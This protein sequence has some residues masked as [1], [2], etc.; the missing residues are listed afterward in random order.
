MNGCKEPRIDKGI[1]T[2]TID[3]TWLYGV[4]LQGDVVH[5]AF[6][7]SIHSGNGS[8]EASAKAHL[9]QAQRTRG[10]A[11]CRVLVGTVAID[12]QCLGVAP[13]IEW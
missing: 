6:S 4:F 2:Q 1:V 5:W 12:V 8:I 11:S 10:R 9:E 13:F 7:R 3:K